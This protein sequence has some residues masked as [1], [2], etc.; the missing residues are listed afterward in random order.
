MPVIAPEDI[1]SRLARD[2]TEGAMPPIFHPTV[3]ALVLFI[4]NGLIFCRALNSEFCRV[5]F[6]LRLLGEL[7]RL[8]VIL[9]EA[10]AIVFHALSKLA[11]RL[12]E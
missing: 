6:R 8:E 5:P 4:P 12:S 10:R 9:F 7:L 1:Y 11:G 2:V 3:G